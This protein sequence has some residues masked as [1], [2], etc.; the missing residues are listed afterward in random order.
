MNRG[1]SGSERVHRS[2]KGI[3]ARPENRK[4]ENSPK[5][6]SDRNRVPSITIM[7]FLLAQVSESKCCTVSLNY[8]FSYREGLKSK[9]IESEFEGVDKSV[10]RVV[11][12]RAR[13]VKESC[14][15]LCP[16][17]DQTPIDQRIPFVEFDRV[18]GG[19][20]LDHCIFLLIFSY[21]SRHRKKTSD[22][23]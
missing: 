8:P 20:R 9:S 11:Y 18:E 17:P 1:A 23:C 19:A 16:I 14:L 5:G 12:S 7:M 13:V 3:F 2:R 22:C 4:V 15:I 10:R 21:V 6:L